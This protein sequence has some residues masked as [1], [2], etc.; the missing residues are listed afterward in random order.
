GNGVTETW[1]FDLDYRPLS[2]A[3]TGYTTLQS[4]SYGYDAADNVVAI[5]DA[6]TASHTQHF[7]Y[8]ALDRLTSA[9]GG[10]GSLGYTYDSVGNRLTQSGGQETSYQYAPRS[11]Q[12]TALTANGAPQSIGY[13]KTGHLNSFNPASGGLSDFT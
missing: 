8:D 13:T 10:Y 1:A 9:T 4:L 7:G 5:T 6:V 12:I 11:N 3:D 2:L